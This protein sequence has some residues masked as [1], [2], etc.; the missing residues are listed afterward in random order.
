MSNQDNENKQEPKEQ[1]K[2]IELID[3]TEILTD[4]FKIF[5]R[6]WAWVLIFCIFGAGLFY[7]RARLQYTP[8]YTASATFTINIQQEQ[9][10]VE[11][12][13]TATFFDNSAAEQ[14]A[15]TFPYILTSG[16]LK[17]KVA[18]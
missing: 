7:V 4:Y 5:R 2:Q 14:M 12:G 16:V 9:Q 3:I 8:Q 6:M 11:D 10:N 17:R 13:G 15:K 18:K 1:Q